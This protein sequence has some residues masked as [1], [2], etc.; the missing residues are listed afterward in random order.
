[1]TGVPNP[2]EGAPR[3]DAMMILEAKGTVGPPLASQVPAGSGVSTPAFQT[4]A[5]NSY[6][7]RY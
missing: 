4:G 7:G 1:M 2:F 5:A 6:H 3:A